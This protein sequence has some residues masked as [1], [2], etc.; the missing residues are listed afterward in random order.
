M[1]AGN[2]SDSI[3]NQIEDEISKL[4]A[5]ESLKLLFEIENRIY[6]I[7]GRESIRYG[8]GVH[9]KHRHIKYH[10]FF[11]DNIIPESKVLD[12]GCGNGALTFDIAKKVKKSNVF[13][14]DISRS[15]IDY[16]KANFKNDNVTYI[17]GDA[18]VDLPDTTFDVIVMSN[19]LEHIEH[20]VKFLKTLKKRYR[21]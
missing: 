8:N 6:S 19:V 1:K 5:S 10:D 14:I 18:L 4:T 12:I 17:C 21:P 7:M 16:A 11:T 2:L 13:G 3:L 9:T 20:R 15:N